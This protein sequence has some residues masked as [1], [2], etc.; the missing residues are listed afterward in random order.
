MKDKGQKDYCEVTE[1]ADFRK[2]NVLTTQIAVKV[3]VLHLT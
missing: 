1:Q 2:V 3:T